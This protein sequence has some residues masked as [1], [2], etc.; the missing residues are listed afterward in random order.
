MHLSS[1]LL[2]IGIAS[3]VSGLATAPYPALKPYRTLRLVPQSDDASS[4]LHAAH[5]CSWLSA[6]DAAWMVA[7]A[8]TFAATR[9]G[10]STDRHGQFPT[11]DFAVDTCRVLDRFLQPRLRGQVLPLLAELYGLKTH[12]LDIDDLFFVKY[13]AGKQARCVGCV[14][15]V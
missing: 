6:E 14:E 15:E 11:T 7:E 12:E 10:W 3:S 5:I 1:L 13:E 8:E 9:G 4:P 2:L